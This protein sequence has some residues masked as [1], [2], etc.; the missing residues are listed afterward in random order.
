HQIQNPHVQHIINILGQNQST[1][2]ERFLLNTAEID[3]CTNEAMSNIEYLDLLKQP[4]DNLNNIQSPES[5]AEHLPIILHLFRFIWLNSSFYNTQ[6][7]AHYLIQLINN[8]IIIFVNAHNSLTSH[9]WDLNVEDVFQY[10]DSFMK[11]CRDLIEIC[12]AMIDFARLDETVEIPQPRFGGTK[13]LIHERV[14]QKVE[15]LFLEHLHTM[16]LKAHKIL[17]VREATWHDDMF[18]FRTKMKDLE[19]II[20]NLMNAVFK[21]MNNVRQGIANLYGFNIYMKRE[22][23]KALFDSMRSHIW[24]LIA[25]KIHS[26]KKK[27]LE[28]RGEYSS[29][30][31]YFSGR[32]LNLHLKKKQMEIAMHELT[33]AKWMGQCSISEEVYHQYEIMVS[34]IRETIVRLYHKWMDDIGDN[35][36][37]QLD[38]YL[39]RR[40]N[41]KPRLLESNLD[42][43]VLNLCREAHHWQYL[44]FQMPVHVV[45]IN[46]NWQTLQ[47][48]SE[49]VLMLVLS[50]N[51]ILN[52]FSSE[53]MSLF[54]ELIRHLDQKIQPGLTRLTWNSE[55]IDIYIKECCE[56]VANVQDFLDTYKK[57]N[58]EIMKLCEDISNTSM[59]KLKPNHGYE[60]SELE[61]ELT[62]M[63]T[64][65]FN[66]ITDTYKRILQYLVVV[67]EGIQTM[68]AQTKSEWQNY[69]IHLNKLLEEAM[70]LCLKNSLNVMYD[71]LHGDETIG[72]LPFLVI[73]ANLINNK[74]DFVPPLSEIKR[75]MSGVLGNFLDPLKSMKQ[76][77]KI[78]GITTSENSNLWETFKNDKS[79]MQQQKLIDDE[80]T[81]CFN[82]LQN[83]LKTWEP[84]SDVWEVNKDM[85]IKRYENLKPTAASFDTEIERYSEMANNVEMQE[86]V[87]I[88]H[89]LD[90]NSDRLKAAI[91]EH[92]S[93]WQQ[94]LT[95]L[96][97]HMTQ[98]SMDRL[99]SKEPTDL[100]S[101]QATL[102]LFERLRAEIPREEEEFP[103]IREQ[104]QTL[105]KR[106]EVFLPANRLARRIDGV[107][108]GITSA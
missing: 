71:A 107:A 99:I 2:L 60:L 65:V 37:S 75:V 84:F 55:F 50:Y 87:T 66:M 52:A 28:E 53:E 16:K 100:I 42:Q 103:K 24:R 56:H 54:K 81:H 85:F 78:F 15:K 88:V 29:S 19:I 59:I 102:R 11:R 104:Y 33:E 9:P 1:Q 83:Y 10:V 41:D 67:Y 17:D 40:S 22:S 57:S 61:N 38:R 86:T 91:I 44:G 12:H 26:T 35:P 7:R 47:F 5:M 48:V 14:C 95:A 92:C 76:L 96:L 58:I 69:L 108:G 63:K 8:Q 68:I 101:M 89:F 32:A 31:P 79:F 27:V 39:M 21:N 106:R 46:D 3:K 93:I 72:P 34:S 64:T 30:T 36:K 51:R 70:K 74:I 45:M 43:N 49:S 82:Q 97:L 23:L 62:V 73:E 105:G 94:K 25:D 98:V 77:P 6:E 18:A 4:C 90:V 20:E 13:G 80:V